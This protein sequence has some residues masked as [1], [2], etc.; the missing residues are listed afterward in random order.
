MGATA[1]NKYFQHG[2]SDA[3]ASGPIPTVEKGEFSHIIFISAPLDQVK[4][5]KTMVRPDEGARMLFKELDANW[6]YFNSL[7]A[8]IENHPSNPRDRKW[9]VV[10]KR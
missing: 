4:L 8:Y 6:L 10:V 7:A 2:Q 3:P 5:I 9:K 1:S